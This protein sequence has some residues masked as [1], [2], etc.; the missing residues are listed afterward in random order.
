MSLSM[1][2]PALAFLYGRMPP[3]MMSQLEAAAAHHHL[4][5][6][7]GGVAGGGVAGSVGVGGGGTID[8]TTRSPSP[9]SG[10]DAGRT[11]W[12]RAM[13]WSRFFDR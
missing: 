9:V 5:A 2:D 4:M 7:V 13:E 6:G 11:T 10:S 3:S 8:L 12:K 1:S